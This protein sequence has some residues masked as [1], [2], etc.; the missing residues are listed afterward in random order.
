[1]IL[2]QTDVAPSNLHLEIVE[3]IAIR[4]AEMAGGVLSEMKA[5]GVQLSVDDFGTGYSSLGRL[6]RFPSIP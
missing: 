2:K 1:L 5:L 4:D 3:T 6:Q